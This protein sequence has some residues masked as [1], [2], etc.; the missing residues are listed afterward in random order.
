MYGVYY[1]RVLWVCPLFGGLSSLG[2]SF[3]GDFTVY[4]SPAIANAPP[5]SPSRAYNSNKMAAEEVERLLGLAQ[6]RGGCTGRHG[7]ALSRDL[8]T[9]GTSAGTNLA[10]NIPDVA[11][12]SVVCCIMFL[13]PPHAVTEAYNSSNVFPG[14]SGTMGYVVREPVIR[15]IFAASHTQGVIARL[16][17]P[18]SGHPWDQSKWPD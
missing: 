6:E 5:L 4:N 9:E 8:V 10:A 11:A 18:K 13:S 7:E 14:D 2:V 12:T 1:T 17:S 3:I 16:A 15:G